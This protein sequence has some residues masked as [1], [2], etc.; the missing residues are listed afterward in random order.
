MRM[1]LT[2]SHLHGRGRQDSHFHR[3]EEA[4]SQCRRAFFTLRESTF[5]ATEKPLRRCGK[6]SSAHQEAHSDVT[7]CAKLAFRRGMTASGEAVSRFL[8]VKIFYCRKAI[9]IHP[10]IHGCYSE[11]A[12]RYATGAFPDRA[13]TLPHPLRSAGSRQYRRRGARRGA[14]IRATQE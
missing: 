11:E 14:G 4:L 10:Y 2:Y 12:V 6:A 1:C 3:P 9:N 13:R 8:I 5:H 7:A